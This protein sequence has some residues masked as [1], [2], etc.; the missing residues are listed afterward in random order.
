MDFLL[1]VRRQ[2]FR[3]S[4]PVWVFLDQNRPRPAIWADLPL[5][6]EISIRPADEIARLDFRGLI[7]LSVA[8]WAEA[9]TDRLRALLVAIVRC[10]PDFLSGVADE[11]LLFAWH[12]E[13]GWEFD[14]IGEAQ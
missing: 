1:A 6:F 3:P 4:H 14:R 11:N 9:L 13:R 2:G 10:R 7:G 12:P 8:V 5:A